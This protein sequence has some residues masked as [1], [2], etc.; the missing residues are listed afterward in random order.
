MRIY[1]P[2]GLEREENYLY[3]KDELE[4]ALRNS[5]ILD[6]IINRVDADG[7]S[8]ID[9]G[10]LYG[11]IE[12]K[13][14]SIRN[15]ENRDIVNK[16]GKVVSFK[17]LDIKDN[18][19]I[20]SR[21]KAQEECTNNYIS[22]LKAG[23]IVKA[24]ITDIKEF[25]AFCDIGCGVEGLLP[26]KLL[27]MSKIIKMTYEL[28]KIQSLYV[29]IKEIGDN[30]KIGLSLKELLGTWEQE[31]SK[32]NVGDVAIGIVRNI[33]DYGVFVEL[34]PNLSVLAEVP[35]NLN[36]KYNDKVSIKIKS[37]IPEKM[38]IKADI[39]NKMADKFT[40]YTNL[41]YKLTGRNI[42]EWTYSPETCN[43]LIQTK[44]E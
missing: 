6:G 27:C 20:L 4:L 41:D 30:G 28:N 9:L 17:I 32:F 19:V 1:N 16:V 25:G 2:E 36:I 14:F 44:F 39:K 31:A 26:V 3:T 7:T 37:I 21:K 34:T 24:K 38:K 33:T 8:Y 18:K 23:D 5:T 42:K 40:G 12:K 22:K 10:G 29:V 15:T 11:S 43:K 35:N 13:E